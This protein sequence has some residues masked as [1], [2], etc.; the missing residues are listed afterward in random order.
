MRIER[1]GDFTKRRGMADVSSGRES[2]FMLRGA[3]VSLE[4]EGGGPVPGIGGL[5]RVGSNVSV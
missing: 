2:E 1:G 4:R 3:E 5:N